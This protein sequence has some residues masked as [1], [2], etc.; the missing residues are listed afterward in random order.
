MFPTSVED[1]SVKIIRVKKAQLARLAENVAY[2]DNDN[3][4]AFLFMIGKAEGGDYHAKYGWHP[5]SAE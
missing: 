5:G 4:K 2:L 1:S 3:V